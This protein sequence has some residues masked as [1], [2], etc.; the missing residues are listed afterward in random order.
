MNKTHI[1]NIL[2]VLISISLVDENQVILLK[3]DKISPSYVSLLV[4]LNELRSEPKP[5]SGFDFPSYAREC[6]EG[7]VDVEEYLTKYNK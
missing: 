4:C 3:S 1:Y 5:K 2:C 6:W 7:L